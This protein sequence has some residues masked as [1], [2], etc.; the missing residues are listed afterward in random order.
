MKL[1]LQSW[2]IK[3]KSTDCLKHQVADF[4]QSH[5]SE[6]P[7]RNDKS[8]KYHGLSGFILIQI[9]FAP[10]LKPNAPNALLC[11][12]NKVSRQHGGSKIIQILQCC[13]YANFNLTSPSSLACLQ[14]TSSLDS[15]PSRSQVASADPNR[16]TRSKVLILGWKPDADPPRKGQLIFR[17]PTTHIFESVTPLLAIGSFTI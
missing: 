17:R 6:H 11:N 12:F 15:P 1:P 9:Y 10:N 8:C 4:T 7:E 5:D 13:R 3:G 14:N 2:Y 16:T